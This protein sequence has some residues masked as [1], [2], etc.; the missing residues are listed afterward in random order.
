MTRKKSYKQTHK[1]VSK[2]ISG[3]KSGHKF[4]HKSR[5]KSR[6]SRKF[7]TVKIGTVKDEVYNFANK[8][9]PFIGKEGSSYIKK[10]SSFFSK[11]P[12]MLNPYKKADMT[13]KEKMIHWFSGTSFAR[14][15]INKAVQNDWLREKIV[16][17][18]LTSTS[19][20]KCDTCQV[21]PKC[22]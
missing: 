9:N 3:H 6:F 15:F 18:A 5:K 8:L 17:N 12:D 1:H 21:C 4:G 11:L 19:C 13:W 20:P 22:E 16:H 10:N 2:N 7:G 14:Y